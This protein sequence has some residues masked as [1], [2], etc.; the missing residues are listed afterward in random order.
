[1]EKETLIRTALLTL[2]LVNQ[3]LVSAGKPVLPIEDEFAGQV[4]S[5]LFTAV[6][7]IWAWWK[8]NS[9]TFEAKEA[10][11]YMKELKKKRD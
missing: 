8:N 3:I 11:K 4:I 2:A 7:S 6:T 1:M 5:S 9:F 10:D